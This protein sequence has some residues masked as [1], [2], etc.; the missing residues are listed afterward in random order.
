MTFREIAKKV[1]DDGWYLV[2][3]QGSHH[4]YNHAVKLETVTIPKHS[5]DIPKP[6]IN[7][8][9]KQAGLK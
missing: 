2:R 9:L 4:H 1:T 6:V 7:S 5:G 3:V 8:I